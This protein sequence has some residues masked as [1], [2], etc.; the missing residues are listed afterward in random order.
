MQ[1]RT[2]KC[3]AIWNVRESK[4]V[5]LGRI[6]CNTCAREIEQQRIAAACALRDAIHLFGKLGALYLSG[7]DRDVGHPKPRE[8]AT[9]QEGVIAAS[10]EIP[11]LRVNIDAYDESPNMA[12]CCSASR[13]NCYEFWNPDR[14]RSGCGG[15]AGTFSRVQECTEGQ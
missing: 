4:R 13:I 3:R 11:N 12:A 2:L 15:A 6:R 8:H 5:V 10:G 9:Q 1:S 14:S 7:K